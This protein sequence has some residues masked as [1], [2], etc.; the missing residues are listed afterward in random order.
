MDQLSCMQVVQS[1]SNLVYDIT[2]VLLAQQSLPNQSVQVDV[3]ELE[4]D[5]NVLFR[6]RSDH[7][8]NLYYVRVLQFLEKHY[9]S[10]G[11]LGI[12]GVLKGIKIFLEGIGLAVTTISYFPNDAV[13]TTA[14]L[15]TDIKALQDVRLYLFVITHYIYLYRPN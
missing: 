8:S 7:P 10:V 12:S 6:V 9:L 15:F 14:N 3:H 1:L 5:I 2:L 4:K 13:R 11:A